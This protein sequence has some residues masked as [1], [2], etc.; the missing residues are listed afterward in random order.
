MIQTSCG[1]VLPQEVLL[2]SS[3]PKIRDDSCLSVGL[4]L[5]VDNVLEQVVHDADDTGVGLEATLRDDQVRELGRKVYV[6][7][8][9]V[10][11]AD[12]TTS[13]KP[14]CSD[15]RQTGVAGF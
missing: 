1:R 15:L 13:A 12:L 9:D 6:R 2:L 7:H 5:Q 3:Q 4:P 11:A 8:F 10:A 14:G